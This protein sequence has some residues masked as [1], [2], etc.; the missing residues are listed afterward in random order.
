MLI[1]NCDEDWNTSG[2][3]VERTGIFV[4]YMKVIRY[5][6]RVHAKFWCEAKFEAYFEHFW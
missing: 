5:V 4:N 6:L 3:V 2:V 1:T